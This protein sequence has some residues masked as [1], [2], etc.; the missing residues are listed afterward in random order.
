MLFFFEMDYFITVDD[1]GVFKNKLNGTFGKEED[2]YVLFGNYI[3]FSLETII[4]QNLIKI[5]Y[6]NFEKITMSK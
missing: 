1:F 3:C 6:V 5:V 2:Q 4:Q